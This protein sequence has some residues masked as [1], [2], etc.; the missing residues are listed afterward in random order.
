[1]IVLADVLN[2]EEVLAVRA[3]LAAAPFREGTATAGAAAG[4]VKHN[5]QAQPGDP[6][7][8]ALARRVR[9]ALEAHAGVRTFA[10]PVRWSGLMF[11]RYGSGQQYGLHTDNAT[12]YGGDGQSLRSDLSFT[13][14]LSDP[15]SYDGGAL[16]VRDRAADRA[17]RLEAG[18]AI[19]YPT[20]CLHRVAPVT[21]GVRLACV[22]WMQSRVRRADQREILYDLEQVRARTGAGEAALLLDKTLGNLLRM[23]GED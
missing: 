9:L 10:R 7:V 22:G 6:G 19:L 23:W 3:G 17:F 1:M 8:I 12:M 4:P 21:R 15:D 11:S 20:G 2:R 18:S 14:F 16:E 13:L 5:E